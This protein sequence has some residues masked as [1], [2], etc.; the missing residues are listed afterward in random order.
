MLGP[1]GTDIT[2]LNAE[3]IAE[4]LSYVE[5]SDIRSFRAT[6]RKLKDCSL[7]SFVRSLYC[8]KCSLERK[9]GVQNIV[10]IVK[11][12][13][14]SLGIRH[15]I[16][17]CDDTTALNEKR[18]AEFDIPVGSQ[19]DLSSIQA[20]LD[21]TFRRIREGKLG[22]P[23]YH[24]IQSQRMGVYFDRLPLLR[25]IEVR[26]RT[27]APNIR[28]FEDRATLK[29]LRGLASVYIGNNRLEAKDVH[30]LNSYQLNH[31][32]QFLLHSLL[33][34][35]RQI[36]RLY[37]GNWL[38]RPECHAMVN[39]DSTPVA[40]AGSMVS[41]H[42]TMVGVD[43]ETLSLPRSL[44][45]SL[46]PSFA[47]LKTLA[48][49]V[50]YFDRPISEQYLQPHSDRILPKEWLSHFLGL[51]PSLETLKLAFHVPR[52]A[53]NMEHFLMAQP[54]LHC[55][56]PL[57]TQINIPR[58]R[59]LSLAS[60]RCEWRVLL[61]FIALHPL[62]EDLSLEGIFFPETR[63]MS[64]ESDV[65]DELRSASRR[66]R[67]L[68]RVRLIWLAVG[69]H[70]D[71]LIQVLAF[72][73]PGSADPKRIEGQKCCNLLLYT[74][75]ICP[76]TDQNWYCDGF[77]KNPCKHV[78]FDSSGEAWYEE[79]HKKEPVLLRPYHKWFFHH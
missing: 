13:Q 4:I 3:L 8:M 27:A 49:F 2:T 64:Q 9:N 54:S 60:T 70:G 47:A 78:T 34:S 10:N 35:G 68:K 79:I 39:M 33:Y 32:F 41:F 23:S 58:L 11:D 28:H 44:Y 36:R 18:R 76:K 7:S 46:R 14:L 48:L 71:Q 63:R 43:V 77:A 30:H 52:E 16:F 59:R 20:D 24:G 40:G 5:P 45:S 19:P 6:C 75:D 73:P 12:D 62:L 26:G 53:A 74:A 66:L 50:H 15:L 42:N 31:S 67:G 51:M 72:L 65:I 22:E 17:Q 37:V 21:R 1:N 57:H 38:Q 56:T 55:W 25:T 61:S 69:Y 29:F